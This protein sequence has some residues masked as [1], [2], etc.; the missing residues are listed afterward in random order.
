MDR[1]VERY[2]SGRLQAHAEHVGLAPGQM[3]NSNVGHLNLGA[4]RV[5]MQELGRIDRAID[6]GSF[7]RNA[8][9]CRAMDMASRGT[10][11]VYGLVSDGGVHGH[12]RHLEAL[13]ELARQRD[14]GRLFVHAITD[15][16]DTPPTSALHYIS[17]LNACLDLH[18]GDRVWGV[19]TVMGRFWAM[20]RDRRWDRTAA[21]YQA[22]VD[23]QGYRAASALQAVEAAYERGETDE[24]VS[25]TVITAAEKAPLTL[26]PGDSVI[27]HNFRADRARQLASCLGSSG[28]PVGAGPP[29][30][31][32]TAFSVYDPDLQ[33][34]AA[35]PPTLMEATVGEVVSAAGLR[36]LR[37]A[38][39]EKYAHVTY[40]YSGGRHAP[41]R[42]ED[43][44]L[45]P[46][47]RVMTYD[48]R[49]EMS[50]GDVTRAAVEAASSRHYDLI[51]VNY[52]NADMVGHTGNLEATVAAVETVDSCLGRLVP[53]LL[54]NGY[55]TLVLSDHGNAEQM[56][57]AE[58]GS[59]ITAHSTNPVPVILVQEDMSRVA[60]STGVLA[61]AGPTILELMGLGVP[62]V[63]T[64]Q[65]LL[66]RQRG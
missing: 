42:G 30:W 65:S 63:M 13:L 34:P 15:G 50:A 35:F 62:E 53:A 38:E 49:P 25:P 3:G 51:V 7:G 56:Q 4:G 27:A 10:L 19:A 64:A 41:F 44:V 54:S 2:P 33:V 9:L 14:V 66:S 36:Q 23:G 47:P 61:D 59:S 40:F 17:R 55:S 18:R 45:V 60:L 8:V 12:I 37:L 29:Q 48:E 24:F 6:D 20:D 32:L 11:H 58:T 21:A 5:V 52:A 1:L 22:M 46:S 43:R 31:H 28:E 26:G 39:T 16:R 57:H